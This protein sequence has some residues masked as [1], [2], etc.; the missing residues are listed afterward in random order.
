VQANEEFAGAMAGLTPDQLWARPGGAASCGFHARH[1][2]GSLDRL[3]TYARGEA[4]SD[5]QLARLAAEK[6]MDREGDWEAVS[7]FVDAEVRRAL[8]QLRA[9]PESALL[10]PRE[11]GRA[12]LPSNVIGLLFHAAEHTAAHAAQAVTT[13]K[14][15]RALAT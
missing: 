5:A 3:F 2:M 14:I 6:T 13:A 7:A 12:K 10:D 1:A 15:V 11:V 4:L 9:T 8:E